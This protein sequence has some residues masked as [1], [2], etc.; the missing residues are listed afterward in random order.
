MTIFDLLF[1]WKL[2]FLKWSFYALIFVIIGI[3][4]FLRMINLSFAHG[5]IEGI[6]ERSYGWEIQLGS[7][8]HF[9]WLMGPSFDIQDVQIVAPFQARISG[10]EF[11]AYHLSRVWASE[12]TGVDFQVSADSLEIDNILLEDVRLKGRRDLDQVVHLTLTA[13]DGVLNT[14][15]GDPENSKT[16]AQILPI[17]KDADVLKCLS[18]PF[19]IRDNV[20]KT[21]QAV[22]ETGSAY[23]VAQGQIDF[24]A[25]QMD[26]KIST[27]S[28]ESKSGVPPLPVYLTGPTQTPS[29]SVNPQDVLSNIQMMMQGK[30]QNLEQQVE[31]NETFL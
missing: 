13:D 12:N 22:I 28:K 27:I 4:L 7:E 2:K 11:P 8:S 16:M 20:A 6:L 23:L 5:V 19:T 14:G 30:S 21:N 29:L 24:Y 25:D 17:G 15:R 10:L 1:A 31:C 18:A 9:A 3:V 26:F